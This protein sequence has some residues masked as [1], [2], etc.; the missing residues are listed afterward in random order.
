MHRRLSFAPSAAGFLW[1]G[2]AALLLV[3]ATGGIA[4]SFFDPDE[5][6]HYV[7]SLFLGD[8][9]RAGLPSPMAFARDYYAHF[10]KLS[11]GHWPPGW[12][13]LL[14]PVFATARP[15]PFGA[16]AL[17]AFVAG[18]PGGLI[19]WAARRT[20]LWRLGWLVTAAYLILPLVL[21]GARRFL[22]DQPV[23]LVVGLAAIAWLRATERPGWTRFLIFAALAAYAPLVKGNGALIALVPAID[24]VLR[25]R[26]RLLREPAL[27]GAA[28]LAMAVVGPWYWLSFKIS[29][30]GFN[31]APGL[32]YAGLALV[33]NGN[34]ILAN[35]G[36]AGLALA[37]TG[38]AVAW[39]GRGDH[40]QTARIS[41]L[42]V[43]MI[44]ATFLF[45]S[46]VPVAIEPRYVT[47]L[48]PWTLVLASIGLAALWRRGTLLARAAAI[49]LGIAA[50][51]PA[52]A[53]LARLPQ[54]TDIDAATL[55]ARIGARPGIWLVDGRSG[56][57]GAVIAAAAYADNG[58]RRVWVARASQW[59]STSDFMGRDYRVTATS[60]AAAR[61]VLDRLGVAGVVSVA[62]HGRLAY[63]HSAIL[64]A[65]LADPAFSRATIRFRRGDGSS[66]VA[67]RRRP[68]EPN[69]DLLGSGSANLEKMNAALD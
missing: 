11:I 49:A 14:A 25:K 23:T 17:S 3:L 45:Q 68:V 69:S 53:N 15:S 54:A 20:G 5:P 12:Y 62:N 50:L 33:A 57:E 61:A 37:A 8:W 60:P 22:L 40:P 19:L 51:V 67:I 64:R 21:D 26:W 29:A 56:G 6:A 41:A 35:V 30:G 28:M 18:L 7:N 44:L 39:A 52:V 13:A 9:I 36:W 59:L 47:P 4:S 32:D 46:A 63:P 65:A 55:S 66:L 1:T 31:Y 43:A 38:S 42:A 48:L 58:R 27:W 24:I 16:L 34:A 2:L 10:P